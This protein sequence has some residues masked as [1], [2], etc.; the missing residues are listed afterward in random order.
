VWTW[1]AIDSDSKMIL[2]YEIGD[3]NAPPMA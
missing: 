1:T 2:A 3:R